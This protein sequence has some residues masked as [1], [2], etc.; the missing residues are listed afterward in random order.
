MMPVL[1]VKKDGIWA[2][3][4]STILAGDTA[5]PEQFVVTITDNGGGTYSADKTFA[6]VYAAGYDSV[7]VLRYSNN[8]AMVFYVA[9]LY[10]NCVWFHA[11]FLGQSSVYLRFYSDETIEMTEIAYDSSLPEVTTDNNGMVLG[12]VNGQ[13]SAVSADISGSGLPE[14]TTDDNGAFLRVVN[15]VWTAVTVANAEE[16]SF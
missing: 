16:A 2:D 4:I 7:A 3:V 1:K 11:D 13:W 10:D 12:V 5:V 8:N 15:G 14:V 6:E 9:G